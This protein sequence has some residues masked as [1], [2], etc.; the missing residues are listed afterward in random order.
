MAKEFHIAEQRILSRYEPG[1]DWGAKRRLIAVTEDESVKLFVR[2]GCHMAAAGVRGFGRLYS[3]AKLILVESR[4]GK[5]GNRLAEGRVTRKVLEAHSE[6]IDA[7]FA[8]P[9]LTSRL[10]PKKTVVVRSSK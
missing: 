9:G 8:F 5:L 4:S 2:E 7:A 3:P 10:E 6:R 1:M